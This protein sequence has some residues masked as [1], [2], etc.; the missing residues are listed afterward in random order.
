[1]L[2]TARLTADEMD[3]FWR[4]HQEIRALLLHAYGRDRELFLRFAHLA[5]QNRE[6]HQVLTDQN[7]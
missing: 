3:S 7:R 4:C 2:H 5:T 6:R 1:M